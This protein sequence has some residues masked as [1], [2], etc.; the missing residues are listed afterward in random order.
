MFSE[1]PDQMVDDAACDLCSKCFSLSAR[2]END[3][4]CHEG[5][6]K[7]WTLGISY[8]LSTDTVSFVKICQN[9]EVQFLL[10]ENIIH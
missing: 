4:D 3:R 1:W 10:K 8:V 9:Q 5:L 6:G 7:H 2:L